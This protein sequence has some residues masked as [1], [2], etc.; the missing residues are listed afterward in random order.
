MHVSSKFGQRTFV[1][2]QIKSME[3][4]PLNYGAYIDNAI[5]TGAL[6]RCSVFIETSSV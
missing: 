6:S 1:Y 5:G 2:N 4:R 3:L